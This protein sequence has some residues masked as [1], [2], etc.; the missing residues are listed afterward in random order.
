MGRLANFRRWFHKL[1]LTFFQPDP[2]AI[3]HK[4]EGKACCV[5]TPR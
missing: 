1:I 5:L 2:L 4:K 3:S